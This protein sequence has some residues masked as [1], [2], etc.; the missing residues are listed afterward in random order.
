MLSFSFHI[1]I[2]KKFNLSSKKLSKNYCL[3]LISDVHLGSNSYK[4]LQRLITKIKKIN[5]DLVLISGDLID[6]LSFN[7]EQL[8]LFRLLELPIFFVTGN[9]EFYLNNFQKLQKSLDN[10]LITLLD[11]RNKIFEE[12]NIIGISDNLSQKNKIKFVKDLTKENFFNICLIHQ[13]SIWEQIY[14]DIEL[15][16]SGHTH[17]GQIFPFN[18]LV[19]FKF[20]YIYGRF[21]HKN[22]NL[23]VSSGAGTWGPKMRLGSSNEIIKLDV[24]SLK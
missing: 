15:M 2:T 16:F 7:L 10:N 6:S 4:H 19:R 5:P 3:V 14:D 8:S 1:I 12:L 24:G 11:N 22:S 17:K 13:P 9:H 23:I 18:L 20:K 21:T